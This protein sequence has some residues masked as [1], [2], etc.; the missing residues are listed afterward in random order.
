MSLVVAILMI[1]IGG[2]LSFWSNQRAFNRRNMAGVEEFKSYADSI[3]KR[4]IEKIARIGGRVLI[5]LGVLF[6]IASLMTSHNR[7]PPAETSATQ[8]DATPA[9]AP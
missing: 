9:T 6:L 4:G 8:T 7:V 2:Y 3:A 5:V 1:A